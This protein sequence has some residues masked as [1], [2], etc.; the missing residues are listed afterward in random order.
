VARGP[1]TSLFFNEFNSVFEE[2]YLLKQR[3]LI[4]G[5]L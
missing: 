4:L 1:L 5:V 2:E 3:M